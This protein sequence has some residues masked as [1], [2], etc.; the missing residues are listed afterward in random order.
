MGGWLRVDHLYL[1]MED[2][3]VPVLTLSPQEQAQR[4]PPVSAEE[5]LYI[6]EL[7]SEALVRSYM[8]HLMQGR[9]QAE[10]EEQRREA[11]EKAA[12]AEPKVAFVGTLSSLLSAD[13]REIPRPD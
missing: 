4:L 3:G 13:A 10:L 8:S 12:A 11:E 2:D 7:A 5:A 1:P 9:L 6:Y